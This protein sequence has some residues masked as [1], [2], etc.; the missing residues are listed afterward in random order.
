MGNVA[1][2]ADYVEFQEIVLEKGPNGTELVAMLFTPQIA[3]GLRFKNLEFG[4][5]LVAL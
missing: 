5:F 1:C 3:R 4:V 2:W